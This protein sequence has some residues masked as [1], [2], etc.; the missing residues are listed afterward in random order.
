MRCLNMYELSAPAQAVSLNS[1]ASSLYLWRGR[2]YLSPG[3]PSCAAVLPEG[4]A[5]TSDLLQL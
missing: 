5:T 1:S 3:S 4:Q 2:S